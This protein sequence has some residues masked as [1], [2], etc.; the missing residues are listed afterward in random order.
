MAEAS[1]RME[2]I[3]AN[4]LTVCSAE[5]MQA[6]ALRYFVRDGAFAA[7]VQESVGVL[8]E[9]LQAAETRDGALILA[10]RSPTETLVLTGDPARLAD[11]EAR[12]AQAADGCLV[13]LSGGLRVL[14]VTGERISDLL[15]RLGG[16][17]SIPR[18]GEARRGRMADV[19]VLAL[20]V[21]AGETLLVVDRVYADH[22][23]GWIRETLLDFDAG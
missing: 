16:T 10:W 5:P 17:E 18:P 7:A 15:C 13:N 6:A 4:G 20:C 19:P 3:K 2:G 22:L 21:R 14:R 9:G 12:V 23:C 1:A 8:P 11:L